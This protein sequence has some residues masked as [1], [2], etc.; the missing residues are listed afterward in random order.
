M[1]IDYIDVGMRIRYFRRQKRISQEEL[2]FRIESTAAYISSIE[3]GK[4]K[5]S[6]QKLV[7][8]SEVLGVTVNDFIYTTAASSP[9]RLGELA[10][11]SF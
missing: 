10:R 1:D 5:P 6:L 7:Q 2:A 8:I 9:Q 4:K 11:L 3:C